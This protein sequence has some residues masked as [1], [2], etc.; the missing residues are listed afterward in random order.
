M[1]RPRGLH[2]RL[3]EARPRAVGIFRL[4]L[5]VKVVA[6]VLGIAIAMQPLP[7]RRKATISLNANR[8]LTIGRN[9]SDV[10]AFTVVGE[11]I[12]C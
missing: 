6:T 7:R 4:K 3:I 10:E 5:R 12:G 2:I 11:L 1:E 8:D 9:S